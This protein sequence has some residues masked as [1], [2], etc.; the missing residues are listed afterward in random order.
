MT[1]GGEGEMRVDGAREKE[2]EEEEEGKGR[3]GGGGERRESGRMGEARIGGHM[4]VNRMPVLTGHC[5]KQMIA[6][7]R[8]LHLGC[9]GVPVLVLA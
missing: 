7:Y 4:Q 9:R 8:W 2:E 5:V 6:K 1:W 3:G